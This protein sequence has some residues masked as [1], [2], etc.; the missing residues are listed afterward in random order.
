MRLEEKS[1]HYLNHLLG[2]HRSIIGFTQLS[3]NIGRSS[4]AKQSRQKNA[5]EH[6]SAKAVRVQA[7]L[8][9]RRAEI[10]RS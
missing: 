3:L 8:A 1:S 7:I 6:L 4:A 10:A 5:I 9:D 2:R